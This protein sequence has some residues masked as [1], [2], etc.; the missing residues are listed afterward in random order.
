MPNRTNRSPSFKA[1]VLMEALRG[2]HTV[3]E[4]SC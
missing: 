2:E 3:S 1:K 4:H